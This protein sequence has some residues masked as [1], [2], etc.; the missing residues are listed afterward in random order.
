MVVK[1]ATAVEVFLNIGCMLK[2][3][4]TWLVSA[5]AL[6]FRPLKVTP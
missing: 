4:K 5:Q 2:Q 6:K 3:L 1:V